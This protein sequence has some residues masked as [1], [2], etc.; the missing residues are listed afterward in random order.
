VAGDVDGLI[1]F[2]HEITYLHIKL[3]P[4]RIRVRRLSSIFIV[5]SAEGVSGRQPGLSANY[6]SEIDVIDR[7]NKAIFGINTRSGSAWNRRLPQV[8]NRGSF[9]T[10]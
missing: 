4:Y 3:V 6:L 10:S 2:I 7:A 9:R 1:S 8:A 5:K